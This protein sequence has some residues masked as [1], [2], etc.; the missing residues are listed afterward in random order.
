MD[1][2]DQTIANPIYEQLG[3]REPSTVIEAQ[4]VLEAIRSEKGYL[5]E[6]FLEDIKNLREHHRVKIEKDYEKKR[7]TE[8][9]YT[10]A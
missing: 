10:K 6:D 7:A 3:N 1:V 9:R 2:A 4:A 8:A 5:S